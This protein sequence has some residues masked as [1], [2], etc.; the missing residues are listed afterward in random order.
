MKNESLES[1]EFI[2]ACW[3][4]ANATY[5][6]KVPQEILDGM[7]RLIPNPNEKS[8]IS[9]DDLSVESTVAVTSAFVYGALHCEISSL[10]RQF[11]GT[12]WGLGLAGLS[13]AGIICK[14]PDGTW[15]DFFNNAVNYFVSCASLVAGVV[16]IFWFDK[17]KK[18][19]GSFSGVAGGGGGANVG[20]SG[21]WKKF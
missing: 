20:G 15:E 4:L 1:P 18:P 8:K 13:A 19:V 14:S 5:K 7:L 6:G 16:Q 2:Q 12:H 3:N 21:S 9:S 10:R 11:D 17:S